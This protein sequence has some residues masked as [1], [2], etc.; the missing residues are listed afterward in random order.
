MIKI[1]FIL[2]IAVLLSL[3]FQANLFADKLMLKSGEIVEGEI[4]ERT[5][6]LIKIDIAGVPLTYYLEDIDSVA[7]EKTGTRI[8]EPQKKKDSQTFDDSYGKAD[9]F[10]IADFW[11]RKKGTVSLPGVSREK[12]EKKISTEKEKDVSWE[13]WAED[14]KDYMINTLGLLQQISQISSEAAGGLEKGNLSKAAANEAAG[15]LAGIMQSLSDISPP[16]D[17]QGYHE[18][19]I[20]SVN[21]YMMGFNAA[22]RNDAEAMDY[23]KKAVESALSAFRELNRVSGEHGAPQEDL[24]LFNNMLGSLE[25]KYDQEILKKETK[26]A[27]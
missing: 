20:N 4:I 11:S 1:K 26:P 27:Y 10:S 12:E 18:K 14:K 24:E 13:E 2:A 9:D 25:Q 6:E 19:I 5:D 22:S 15:K 17:L 8:R 23:Q 3:C 7:V 16:E 21:D